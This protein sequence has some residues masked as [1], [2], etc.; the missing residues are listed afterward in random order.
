MDSSSPGR[1]GS[2]SFNTVTNGGSSNS[3]Q[4]AS[5]PSS[6][7]PADQQGSNL[8]NENT[9]NT[10]NNN[11][12]GHSNIH[13]RSPTAQSK[14]SGKQTKSTFMG[15]I[16][17]CCNKKLLEMHWDW[18][19]ASIQLTGKGDEIYRDCRIHLCVT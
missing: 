16:W 18:N 1:K 2:S 17:D 12:N 7:N 14:S 5:P 13:H 11:R 3:S 8:N 4:L 15:E 19:I 10:S 9:S 6:I